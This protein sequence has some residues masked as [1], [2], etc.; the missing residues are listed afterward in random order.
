MAKKDLKKGDE[1][2]ALASPA[3]IEA[4]KKA[5][6]IVAEA[7]KADKEQTALNKTFDKDKKVVVFI[8]RKK[9]HCLTRLPIVIRTNPVTGV[10]ETISPGSDIQFHNG[11]FSTSDSDEIKYIKAKPYFGSTI[12]IA[13]TRPDVIKADVKQQIAK[14]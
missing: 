7:E 13:K 1:G 8:S 5:A 11:V 3:V 9:E 12:I 2:K 6:D 10:N 4:R 14:S